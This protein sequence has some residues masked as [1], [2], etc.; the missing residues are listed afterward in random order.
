MNT[1]ILAVDHVGIAVTNLEEALRFYRETLGLP[2]DPIEDKPEQGV[3]IAR[4]HVGDVQLELIESSDWDRTMQRY[5]PHQGPG[6]Y[7][8]GLRVA[9]VD[10]AVVEFERAAVPVIDH[11]PREGDGMR[12]S[13]VHPSA[14]HG[15]LIELVTR[16]KSSE[17]KT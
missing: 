9:D 10:A 13:F 11:Q 1:R 15:T 14:A 8:I 7:H 17:P 2:A 4:V 16:R 5:L 12:V 3:R 6:V